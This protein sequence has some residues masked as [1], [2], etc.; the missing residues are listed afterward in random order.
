MNGR[1]KPHRLPLRDDRLPGLDSACQ[2]PRRHARIIQLPTLACI[3]RRRGWNSTRDR[4]QVTHPV[5]RECAGS[6]CA[7]YDSH[8]SSPPCA[9]GS[10]HTPGQTPRPRTR[11]ADKGR[12]RCGV[13]RC[14]P[15][16][17]TVCSR[18]PH[19]HRTGSAPRRTPRRRASPV[20]LRARARRRSPPERAT[21]WPGL[22]LKGRRRASAFFTSR[23]EN[24]R[25]TER[26]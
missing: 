15:A 18:C 1:G 8:G 24:K 9:R 10:A 14:T 3:A 17:A 22:T 19:R 5:A 25:T 21:G 13:R 4:V 6:C 26:G 20:A 2:R 11:S 7:A 16:A 12:A 23:C